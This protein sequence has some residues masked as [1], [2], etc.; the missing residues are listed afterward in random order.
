MYYEASSRRI[1]NELKADFVVLGPASP[2]TA[3]NVCK[4]Y[5]EKFW[6]RVKANVEF[7]ANPGFRKVEDLAANEAWF[8]TAIGQP[9][10]LRRF[11]TL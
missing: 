8:G 5:G 9:P 7:D 10:N 11:T 3:V 2:R 1:E 4:F 6:H